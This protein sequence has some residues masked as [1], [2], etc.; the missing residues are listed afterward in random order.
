MDILL[1]GAS[2]GIGE[3]TARKIAEKGEHRLFLV[4]RNQQKL[5]KLKSRIE[6]IN[7]HSEVH[8]LALD[9]SENVSYPGIRE[10]LAT[11]CPALD[12]LINNAG[13]VIV[14]PFEELDEKDVDMHF[15]VN[16]MAPALLTRE[17]LPLLKKSV[18]PHVVN[19]SSMS[20]FQGSQKFPG[21]TH[22]SAS[23][24]ALA[25]LT[26]CLSVEFK[27]T[28]SFNALCIGAVQTEM[29]AQAFPGFKA[30]VDP[31]RMGEYIAEFALTAHYIM[32]GKVLP[33]SMS[34]P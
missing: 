5:N 33:L 17:L 8:V 19:I 27:G 11:H 4:A 6:L 22:Y 23:K 21:L 1:T 25:S 9:L 13:T 20:G 32:N 3:A 16:Y 14:K 12:I 10:Y 7:P 26:E 18:H 15:R 34:A 24:A 29:L 28:I 2:R 31:D 30:P